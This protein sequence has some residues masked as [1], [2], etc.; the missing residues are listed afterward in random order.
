MQ[1][2]CKLCGKWQGEVTEAKTLKTMVRVCYDCYSRLLLAKDIADEKKSSN[3][4]MFDL[5]NGYIK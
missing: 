3:D 4:D 2:H 1:V 5:W